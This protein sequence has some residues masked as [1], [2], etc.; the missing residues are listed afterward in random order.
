MKPSKEITF[1]S[2]TGEIQRKDLDVTSKMSEDYFGMQKDP[3]QIPATKKNRDWVYANAEFCLNIVR[4]GRKIIGYAFLL[5]CTRA[6]MDK[7]LSKNINEATLLESIKKKSTSD[8]PETIYLCASIFKEQ[9]RK[10]GLATLAFKKMIDKLTPN[11]NYKPVLF[12]WGYSEA[13]KRLAEKVAKITDLELRAR[14]D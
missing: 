10:Q 2:D 8:S 14:L 7:F 12:Y 13:V 4:D 5:P 9:Y 3:D 6:L 11:G 1:S